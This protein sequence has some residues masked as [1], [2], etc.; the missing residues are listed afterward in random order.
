MHQPARAEPDR[1]LK[2]DGSFLATVSS[3]ERDPDRFVIFVAGNEVTDLAGLERMHNLR[4][5]I[6]TSNQINS[7]RGLEVYLFFVSRSRSIL[8]LDCEHRFHDDTS[9]LFYNLN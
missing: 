3:S 4:K 9:S 5:L 1:Y 8:S 2:T 7:L 6:V